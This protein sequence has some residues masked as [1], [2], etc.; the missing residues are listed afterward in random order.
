MHANIR[1]WDARTP[2]HVNSDFYGI[3]DR[4]PTTWFAP[5]EWRDLGGLEGKELAHLQCHLGTETLAFARKGARATGLDFSSVSV[6]EAR[7]IARQAGLTID[8]VTA[9]VYDAVAALGPERFDIVY[10]GKGALCYLP[11]LTAWA[12]TISRLL[13]PGGFLYLME[14]HPMFNALGPTRKPDAPDH[15]VVSHD[16]LA[17]RGA[18]ERDSTHSYTDG[19]ALASDTVHYEW[20]HGLGEVVTAV[21]RSGLVVESLTETE[22]LPWRRW[23]LMVQRPDGWWAMPP[24]EPRFPVMYGLKASKVC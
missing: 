12:Q 9:D 5:F 17:G 19:P 8:Y 13:K 10:T 6:R 21:A 18:V 1:N 16:Y 14:F 20:S 3:G 7:R 2:I 11:D 15:L 4:D 23:P 22:M 24:E